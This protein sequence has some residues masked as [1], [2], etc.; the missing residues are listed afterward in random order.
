MAYFISQEK[1]NAAHRD[2]N[3][4]KGDQHKENGRQIG[5]PA[6]FYQYG[7]P[8]PQEYLNCCGPQNPCKIGEHFPDNQSSHHNDKQKRKK[9]T[10]YLGINGF[11][12]FK[13]F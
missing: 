9:L 8:S 4:D 1:Y 11:H 2:Q 3:A 5:V 6:P 7:H 12:T 13:S 10:D